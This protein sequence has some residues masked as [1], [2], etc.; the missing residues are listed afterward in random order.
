MGIPTM[1]KL[2]AARFTVLAVSVCWLSTLA[3]QEKGASPITP[4]QPLTF[5]KRPTP[6]PGSAAEVWATTYSPDGDTLAVGCADKSVRLY[7]VQAG[8]LRI[9][10]KGHGDVV[11]GIAFS[12]D[13]KTLASASHDKTVK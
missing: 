11:P 9:V 8:Q 4:A 13:G 12:P 5:A 2:T 3:A 10:L 6:L 1:H 7:D